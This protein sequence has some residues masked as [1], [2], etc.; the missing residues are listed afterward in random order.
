MGWL[1]ICNMLIQ[2]RHGSWHAGRIACEKC[3]REAVMDPG[4]D[5]WWGIFIATSIHSLQCSR[6]RNKDFESTTFVLSLTFMWLGSWFRFFCSWLAGV[7]NCEWETDWITTAEKGGK[8]HFED[9]IGNGHFWGPLAY[10]RY[11]RYGTTVQR[12]GEDSKERH[13]CCGG[14][15]VFLRFLF[16]GDCSL[17]EKIEK[18][19]GKLWEGDALAGVRTSLFGAG[20]SKSMAILSLAL[21]QAAW[22]TAWM[23]QTWDVKALRL[24]WTLKRPIWQRLTRSTWKHMASSTRPLIAWDLDWWK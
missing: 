1:S 21:L 22:E 18:D 2:V 9:R 5:G 23:H 4:K 24:Q 10:R 6:H 13:F 17:L 20:K 8:G 16:H 11:G 12:R 14:M 7:C 19:G 15:C 3:I